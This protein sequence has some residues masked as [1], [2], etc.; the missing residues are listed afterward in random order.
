M[1]SSL[2]SDSKLNKSVLND[3]FF[4]KKQLAPARYPEEIQATCKHGNV[5]CLGLRSRFNIINRH[6]AS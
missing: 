1:S 5:D 6:Q 3:A 4:G 2:V